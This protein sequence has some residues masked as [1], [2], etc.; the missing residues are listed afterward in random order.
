M[1]VP[2]ENDNRSRTTSLR[3]RHLLQPAIDVAPNFRHRVDGT[4]LILSNRFDQQKE[5][6]AMRTTHL[7]IRWTMNQPICWCAILLFALPCIAQDKNAKVKVFIFA[8]QSNMVGADSKVKD[9]KNF[10]P[11]AGL[12][13]PQREVRFAY[14]IGR[15]NKTQSKSW[16]QL[17]PIRNMVGP[18]L[19]FAKIISKHTQGKIAIIKIAAGGTHLGGDWNPDRP[20]GFKLYP[21]ALKFVRDSLAEL[22]KKDVKYELAGM[23]WH[24]GEND[25]FNEQYMKNYGKNLKNFVA[26]WRKDLECSKLPFFIGELCTKTIWGM[27]LRPR[28]YAISLGQKQVAATDPLAHYVP[29]SHVGVEIGNPVGLHYHYGTLGQLQHG[30][31]YANAWL[32]TQGIQTDKRRNLK[33]WP[34]QKNSTIKL[35]VLAGHRN[36]E[37]ERAFIQDL[38]KI[39][40]KKSLLQPNH[41]VAFRYSIGGGYRISKGW[42]PLAAAGYYDTFGPELS[43]AAS[44]SK[45]SKHQIA[46]AKFTHSGSQI[47]DWTPAGSVAKSRNLYRSFIKFVKQTVSDLEARG[48]T[49]EIAGIFYHVGENDMSYGPFRKQSAAGVA[50]LIKQSRIDLK[51]SELRWFVSQ[52]PPTKHKRVNQI[53]VVSKFTALAEN[54]PHT[55]HIKAFDLDGREKRLV[56]ATPGIIQLGEKLADAYIKNQKQSQQ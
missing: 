1:P 3:T 43:F 28:M 27:D 16:E 18:E 20:T 47:V 7:P 9:I 45:Q 49:V 51:N 17:K 6:H 31:N 33:K 22:D 23:M 11:Y 10:P 46:I 35:L 13:K 26:R 48:H 4:T 5:Y 36:M 38:E 56:I 24:Q 39:E 50:S 40:N 19:S 12:D 55:I 44:I 37:G 2:S 30:E 21:L 8:G 42:E 52:Q 53:D 34:Y 32:K 15:E 14:C 29:T 41:N 54:D 25:M